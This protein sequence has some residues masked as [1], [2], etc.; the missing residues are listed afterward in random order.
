MRQVLILINSDDKSGEWRTLKSPVTQ[1]MLNA[2]KEA[3]LKDSPEISIDVLSAAALWSDPYKELRQNPDLVYC[4]LTI[5]LPY[6]LEFPLQKIFMDCREII[7]RRQWVEDHLAYP[8]CQGETGLGDL[9]LPIIWTAKKPLYAE[10]IGEGV[11]PNAYQQPVK[12]EQKT[13]KSLHSLADQL[14]TA[15]SAPPSVYLLQFRLSVEKQ[16]IFD[17]LWPFPAAPAI[18]SLQSQQLD[19]FACYW[20]CLTNQPLLDLTPLPSLVNTTQSARIKA[21]NK[22][23]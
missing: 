20:R 2:L 23:R 9:W 13:C 15:L 16:V 21:P 12:L 22:V 17:R 11:M 14:L 6:W 8:T 5:Q 10:V 4:P 3:I 19:L 18:A 7:A 1:R